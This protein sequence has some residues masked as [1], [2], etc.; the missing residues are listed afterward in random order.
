MKLFPGLY[1]LHKMIL[2]EERGSVL[3]LVALSMVALIG[4]TALV[5]DVGLVYVERVKVNNAVDA[6]ALAG[7]LE[8]MNNE[9]DY[10]VKQEALHY[11]ALNDVNIS[12]EDVHI[13][14]SRSEITVQT[15]RMVDLYFAQV[16]GFD[17]LETG[18]KATVA[19]GYPKKITRIHDGNVLPFIFP[20]DIY[21]EAVERA[22]NSD[23]NDLED[24]EIRL[25]EGVEDDEEDEEEDNDEDEN[26]EEETEHFVQIDGETVKGNWGAIRLGDSGS[27]VQNFRDA[28][29]GY[30][31]MA[32]E[33]EAMGTEDGELEWYEEGTKPGNLFNKLDE[34]VQE[35]LD[36]AEDSNEVD[37]FGLIPVVDEVKKDGQTEIRIV[38]FTVFE[39]TGTEESQTGYD[40]IGH[41]KNI[42]LDKITGEITQDEDYNFGAEVCRL[43]E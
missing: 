37:P 9:S 22:N 23:E 7:G 4:M 33:I 32:S 34:N 17:Q 31:N 36:N 3:V 6:A 8:L 24:I 38:G 16:L 29:E 19:V 35:R 15:A 1:K 13:N 20:K 27:D 25:M 41:L 43:V 40:I 12:E 39:V 42:S 18:A 2:S 26:D 21:D 30:L 5:V 10:E 28:V 11:A 14:N